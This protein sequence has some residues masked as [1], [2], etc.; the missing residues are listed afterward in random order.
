MCFLLFL[1]SCAWYRSNF[2]V[3]TFS[4]NVYSGC[5]VL[6]LIWY[7]VLFCLSRLL[8]QVVQSDASG[9]DE[10]EPVPV[11]TKALALFIRYFDPTRF[12][13]VAHGVVTLT[14][15]ALL[16]PIVLIWPEARK[17]NAGAVESAF[18]ETLLMVDPATSAWR[19]SEWV[20]FRSLR[21]WG[22]HDSQV[23]S[24]KPDTVPYMSNIT[25][26]GINICDGS[27]AWADELL[28]DL[29]SPAKSDKL[30]P[31]LF[32]VHGGSWTSGD[33]SATAMSLAYFLE[34]G[35]AV[36]SPQYTLG[37]HGY[38][39]QEMRDQLEEAFKYVRSVAPGR[40]WDQDRI[41]V[42]GESAGGQLAV[43]LAYTLR[44][45]A[46]RAVYSAYGATN[47]MTQIPFKQCELPIV[48]YTLANNCTDEMRRSLS[49]ITYVTKDTPPTMT[50][51]GTW[52][53]LVKY[54]SS[55]ELHDAL[56]RAGVKNLLVPFPTCQHVFEI[57][58]H[59]APAQMQRYA[60]ERFFGAKAFQ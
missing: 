48:Q 1:S 37:C 40:G 33:K 55:V 29:Y 38:S 59:G 12:R 45:P 15:V 20:G 57:G 7:V 6:L 52:D 31:V 4:R 14:L 25:S 42:F 44:S 24:F 19:M 11:H 46:V 41:F 54:E 3:L 32:H 22:P 58:Y 53:T 9:Q 10:S 21:M 60:L 30:I 13:L 43:L 36:A 8:N 35:Y 5:F 47:I 28:I 17:L 2:V 23:G 56:S 51:H 50:H 39:I 34:R 18:G 16:V 49:A 26:K 27:R